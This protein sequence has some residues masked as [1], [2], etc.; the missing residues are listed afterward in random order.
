MGFQELM[1]A[2]ERPFVEDVGKLAVYFGEGLSVC[3]TGDDLLF[4]EVKSPEIVDPMNVVGMGMGKEDGVDPRDTL[5]YCLGTEVG[6]CV[7]EYVLAVMLDQ[8]G[9]PG[10]LVSRIGGRTDTASA[11]DHGDSGR[12][13]AAENGEFH[14]VSLTV[15]A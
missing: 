2:V 1:V 11:T 3:I 12:C 9:G 15:I 10:P 8:Q 4:E 7:Y 5:P 13:A 6:R 14:L